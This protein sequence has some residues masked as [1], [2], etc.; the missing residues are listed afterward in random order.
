MITEETAAALESPQ[1]DVDEPGAQLVRS[2]LADLPEDPAQRAQVRLDRLKA[3]FAAS[4]AIVAEMYRDEDWKHL[5]RDDGS[6]YAS[7][8][9]LLTDVMGKSTSMA[10][11]YVQGARDFWLPLSELTVEGT[12]IEITSG[13]VAILGKD[14]IADAVEVA[15][16]QLDGVDDPE[17]ASQVISDA[18]E[19]AKDAKSTPRDLPV[20]D[21]E[22]WATADGDQADDDQDEWAEDN[23]DWADDTWDGLLPD[24]VSTAESDAD[25][26]ADEGHD[27][28]ERAVPYNSDD[29]LET[30][31]DDVRDVARAL[32][33]L[34]HIDPKVVADAITYDTR[35]VLLP[36]RDATKKVS[37]MQMMVETSPWYTARA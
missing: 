21:T 5:S 26:G 25:Q 22:E 3:S 17:V 28:M 4:L 7:L 36:V 34:A 8:A 14:G 29:T 32:N 20:N 6:P 2:A 23:G 24:N 15:S 9:D 37:M 1:G 18:V 12:R 27:I 35:G 16:A 33:L 19:T 11:R 13:D 10:R 30:L 31:P